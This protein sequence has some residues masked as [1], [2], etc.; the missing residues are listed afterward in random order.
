MDPFDTG[1]PVVYLVAGFS[2]CATGARFSF[3][4]VARRQESS[5]FDSQM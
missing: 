2:A 3:F 1:G 5:S 4:V